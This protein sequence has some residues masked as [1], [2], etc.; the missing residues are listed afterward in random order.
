MAMRVCVATVS[1]PAAASL[2]RRPSVS[3]TYRRT[4]KPGSLPA[5]V[6]GTGAPHAR[7]SRCCHPLTQCSSSR[8]STSA[9]TRAAKHDE[10]PSV[11]S[12]VPQTPTTVLFA[13]LAAAESVFFTAWPALATDTAAYNPADGSKLFET[14]AGVLYILL[15][16]WFLGRTISRRVNKFTT[17]RIGGGVPSGSSTEEGESSVIIQSDQGK[18]ATPLGALTGAAIA[19][20]I[21]TVLWQLC[22]KV[23]DYF[24]HQAISTQFTVQKLQITIQTITRGM[25]YLC[26]F[27]FAAN[28]TGLIGLAAAMVLAPDAVKE[29]VIARKQRDP[30]ADVSA[31]KPLSMGKRDDRE[32]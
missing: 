11:L 18:A 2:S 5:T 26:T 28:G 17:E 22:L 4:A 3:K 8:V 14:I 27:I 32:A 7:C 20:A 12:T 23:D 16:V 1:T 30:L 13:A 19:F 31:S 24:D 10:A 6:G 25:V 9:V 21:S 15:V 29:P